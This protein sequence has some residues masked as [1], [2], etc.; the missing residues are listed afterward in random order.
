MDQSH[1]NFQ[2]RESSSYKIHEFQW[3]IES[4]HNPE[5]YFIPSRELKQ[6]N[7]SNLNLYWNFNYLTYFLCYM[8]PSFENSCQRNWGDDTNFS[9]EQKKKGEL[10][11]KHKI[12]RLK[13]SS[14]IL[15]NILISPPAFETKISM[16]EQKGGSTN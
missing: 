8:I 4:I 16:K 9:M 11:F 13:C 14:L 5:N 10:N 2:P 1:S 7:N 12:K 6:T 15:I 3:R